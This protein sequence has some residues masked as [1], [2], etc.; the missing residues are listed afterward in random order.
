MSEQEVT[1]ENYG[2][3]NAPRVRRTDTLQHGSR[4][5]GSFGVD[6]ANDVECYVSVREREEHAYHG[7]D[8]WYDVPFEGD[9]YAL[10]LSLFRVLYGRE[11]GRIYIAESDTGDVYHFS[12]QQFVDGTPINTGGEASGRG[13]EK[14]VQKVVPI[15]DA[16]DSWEDH[17]DRFWVKNSAF[18]EDDDPRL[19]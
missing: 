5:V 19:G 13:Y 16:I 14:D 6:V 1:L 18:R 11:V 4:T 15:A 12:F 2:M 7:A 10:S 9:A 17:Y 3:S 8:P